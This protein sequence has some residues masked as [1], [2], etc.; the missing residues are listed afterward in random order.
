[1]LTPLLIVL[2]WIVSP[3]APAPEKPAAIPE[4]MQGVV[5]DGVARPRF[6]CR[7]RNIN[8]SGSINFDEN[9]RA[10]ND[11][12]HMY[13][14]FDVIPVGD[15]ALVAYRGLSITKAVTDS[16]DDM[17]LQAQGNQEQIVQRRITPLP[18][19]HRDPNQGRLNLNVNFV[20]PARRARRI[21]VVEGALQVTYATGPL[22][23]ASIAPVREFENKR[24]RI[25]G[26]EDGFVTITRDGQRQNTVHVDLSAGAMKLLS[27]IKFL[28]ADDLPLQANDWGG[29]G[30]EGN[31][32]RSFNLALDDGSKVVLVFYSQLRTEPVSFE[33]RNIPLPGAERREEWDVVIEALPRGVGEPGKPAPRREQLP[34]EIEVGVE[35]AG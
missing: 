26:V 27:E 4:A 8:W 35:A 9:G 29:G 24:I 31:V 12:S 25:G 21:D 28:S 3:A 20:M 1:M 13:L 30:G 23:E 22:R 14:Q 7:P 5:D 11:R 33:M 17:Q 19:G 34:V 10:T 16:G 15:V 2:P 6:I 32:R 18:Q